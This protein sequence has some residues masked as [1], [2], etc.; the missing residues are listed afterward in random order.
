MAI[1]ARQTNLLAAEDWKKIYQS[2]QEADFTSYDYV[3]LRKTMIDYLRVYYPEDFNDFTDSSEFIALVDLIAFLG[4]SLAFRTD[5]NARE[6]FIDTAERRDSI[7]KL[8]RLINYNPKRSIPAS[9]FLKI[10]SIST[11]ETL[12]DSNGLNLS[13]LLVNWNDQGNDN[14]L[15]QFNIILNATLVNSQIIGKPG[16]S[17]NINGVNTDEYSVNIIQNGPRVFG[18]TSAIEGSTYPFEIVSGTSVDKNYVYE[19]APSLTSQF[20]ILYRN[21]NYGNSSSNTGFFLYFKQGTLQNQD[22]TVSDSIPNRVINVNFNNINNNDVWLYLLNTTGGLSDLW[23]S[24]PTVNGL[25]VIY[26]KNVERNLYQINSRSADQIDLVFGDGSFSNIPIGNFRVYYRVSNGLSYKITPEEMK[27]IS[28]SL[29]YVSRENRI[30]VLTIRA[31]LQYTVTNASSRE[32]LADIKQKAPQQYYTQNRMITGEDYNILPYTSFSNVLKVKSINRTSSG[33][34]RFLDVIDSTGKYSSTNIFADDGVIYKD[35][36]IRSTKFTY[37][38]VSDIIQNINEDILNIVNSKEM[39]HFYYENYPSFNLENYSWNLSTVNTNETTGYFT[40]QTTVGQVG[41]TIITDARYIRKGSVIKFVAPTQYYFDS[42]N[43]L[44]PG[45]STSINDRTELYVTVM[46]V[47]G[48]GTNNGLGNLSNGTGPITLSIKIPTGAR[49]SKIYPVFKNSFTTFFVEKIANLIRSLK[50]FGLT[51]V[52]ARQAWDVILEENLNVA[53]SFSL[54]NQ[55]STSASAADNSWLIK[56]VYGPN[57]YTVFYRG[58]DYIFHSVQDT[59]FFFDERV[60]IYDSKSGSVIIDQIKCL[61]T[62]NRPDSS[63]ALGTDIT[64]NVYRSYVDI[65]GYVNKDKIYIT[66]A[67]S[68][69]DGTPD[70]PDLF[71]D[72]VSPSTNRK[73]KFIFFKS[74]P[75]YNNFETLILINNL[76]VVTKYDTVLEIENNKSLFQLGQLFYLVNENK[77]YKLESS[78]LIEQT[79]YYAKIGRQNLSFQYR[80]NSPNNRRI[81]PSSTNITDIY[82]L[83]ANY[84]KEFRAWLQD[85]TGT[86][87]KPYE[88]TSTELSIEFSSLDDV[89]SISDTIIYNSA[90]FKLLF[91][92]K[93]A[94]SL[95]ATFKIIKNAAVNVSDNDIKTSVINAINNYFDIANWEFGE[96][97]YFSELS[98]Y[99]HRVL[100][101]NVA[102]ILIVPTNP[103]IS[104]GSLYQINAEPNEIIVSAATVDNVEII[105]AITAAQLNFSTANTNRNII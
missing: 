24:V 43:N 4:Q 73:N 20:N 49:V 41:G 87:E 68:N 31:S 88:P 80:H 60:K 59:T 86:I 23:Q 78:G 71:L 22:F 40:Q 70:N 63:V 57:G 17:Q 9:G 50:T 27:N 14:W 101:P 33:I 13:N 69:F 28:I 54:S 72:L 46:N 76:T 77:F 79:N 97:F 6:N 85:T 19:A 90:K 83:T 39:L 42:S 3:T 84:E 91:G 64:W 74:I 103:N 65:D 105:S 26:N 38:T 89:K 18:F 45:I 102:S 48:D 2:F 21:D 5:L 58:V 29:S 96:T 51:Y 10:D 44:L 92:S 75:G 36:F 35:S 7:L 52:V 47:V 32:S 62:N 98:A 99:L 93:A 34:S 30:E 8:A 12:F 67:D 95:Q 104:F 81:D 56:F 94:S 37:N 100:S 53:D 61:K 55:S 1:N 82:L 15:E 25:N 16:N 66:Y 11:S